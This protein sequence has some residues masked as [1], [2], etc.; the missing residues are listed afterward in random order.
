MMGREIMGQNGTN[1]K[2]KRHIGLKIFLT[3]LFLLLAAAAGLVICFYPTYKAAGYLAEN[4]NFQKMEY[5]LEVRIDRKELDGAKKLLIDTM[6]EVTGITDEEL[7]HLTIRGSVDGDVIYA[8]IYPEGQKNPLTELYLSDDLDVVN[9]A[10]LYS[11]MRENVCGQNEMLNYLFPVWEEH[12]YMSLEQAEDMFGV[13]L[14]AFRNFKLSFRDLKL[15]RLEY[16]GI[17][18]LMHRNKA[19][20]EERFTFQ[21]EGLNAELL[22]REQIECTVHMED[23]AEVL[24]ELSDKLSGLGISFSGEKLRILDSLS[25]AAEIREDTV[26]EMPEDLVSQ[27]M[28]DIVKGIRAVIRELKDGRLF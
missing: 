21:I 18:A 7:C 4:L 3:F 13:D 5:T 8:G 19:G 28:V 9:G 17:L 10:M 23:P 12:R 27:N 16:F 22:P 20:E 11:A 15:S 25:V 26:L 1:T 24:E 2:Q 6:A 14:S